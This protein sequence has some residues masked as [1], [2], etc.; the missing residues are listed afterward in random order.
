MVCPL[1]KACLPTEIIYFFFRFWS[2]HCPWHR[3]KFEFFRRW[4]FRRWL[5]TL[6]N[7]VASLLTARTFQILRTGISQMTFL[8]ASPTSTLRTFRFLVANSL[9]SGACDWFWRSWLCFVGTM[10]LRMTMLL[11]IVAHLVFH[12]RGKVRCFLEWN[13][14]LGESF[15]ILLDEASLLGVVIEYLF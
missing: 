8:I 1:T 13:I 4:F 9:T 5:R 15:N 7:H 6:I 12:Y 10:C 14:L 2:W 11:A 3:W